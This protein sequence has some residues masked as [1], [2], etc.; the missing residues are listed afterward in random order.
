MTPKQMA[1][2]LFEQMKG[3]RVKHTHSKK[4]AK[5]AVDAII[6]ANPHQ[7]PL[8]NDNPK[9]TIPFWMEV[10]KELENTQTKK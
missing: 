9:S 6:N 10:K 1:D 2:Q 8:N 3:F 7:N 4:C 5:I